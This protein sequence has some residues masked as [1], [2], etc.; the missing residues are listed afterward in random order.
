MPAN[1]SRRKRSPAAA[2]RHP[3]IV[4]VYEYGE[5]GDRSYIVMA[6][7]EGRRLK[8]VLD[9]GQRFALRETLSV[10][11]QI[12]EAWTMRTASTWCIGISSRPTSSYSEEG[13]LQ[14]ADFGI[15]RIDA[16][17]LTLT[18]A[19]LGTPGYMSPEQCQGAPSVTRGPLRRRGH[20]L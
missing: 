7:I 10:M 2:S 13:H 11:E 6:L 16:S 15:A 5:D 17:T 4:P 14:V 3:N 9:G 12:L 1:A 18:G 8:D 19:V 20:P